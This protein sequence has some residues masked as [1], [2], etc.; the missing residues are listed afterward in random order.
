MMIN[1]VL[2]RMMILKMRRIISSSSSSS[3]SCSSSCCCCSS[4]NCCCCC[5]CSYSCSC[6]CSNTNNT[7]RVILI[8]HDNSCINGNNN[9]HAQI[10]RKGRK[11]LEFPW[12]LAMI[13]N[14][15]RLNIALPE[16]QFCN[17]KQQVAQNVLKPKLCIFPPF[18]SGESHPHASI[19]SQAQMTCHA[20]IGRG[21]N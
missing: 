19:P 20:L 6:S 3:S 10:C 7:V 17:L 2:I 21:A 8:K 9:L 4:S 12:P 11:G 14:A 16:T 18:P 13:L 1:K 15:P 5:S